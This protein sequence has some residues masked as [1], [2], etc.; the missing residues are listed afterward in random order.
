MTEQTTGRRI[1]EGEAKQL[2]GILMNPE[3]N[4]SA[5]CVVRQ[6]RTKSGEI[7][8]VTFPMEAALPVP[9]QAK[10]YSFSEGQRVTGTL[11]DTSDDYIYVPIIEVT[12][13]IDEALKR[14]GKH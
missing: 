7:L 12:P 6:Y 13:T 9:R 3:L 14:Y 8:F 11:I 10:G 2:S 5:L 1:T 4:N